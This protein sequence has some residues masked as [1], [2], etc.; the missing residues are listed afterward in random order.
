MIPFLNQFIMSR[1]W[2]FRMTY[3]ISR[4]TNLTQNAY[5]ILLTSFL[6]K[7][8]FTIKNHLSPSYLFYRC[9]LK[10]SLSVFKAFFFFPLAFSKSSFKVNFI[11][12]YSNIDIILV[13]P[14]WIRKPP[15]DIEVISGN[16]LAIPCLATGSPK[17]RV[18][19]KREVGKYNDF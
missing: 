15:K 6:K 12:S 18:I 13:P 2:V 7:K 4:T 14:T 1:I 9:G 3:K 11:K 5:L 16:S 17:P 19:W 10:T 8:W